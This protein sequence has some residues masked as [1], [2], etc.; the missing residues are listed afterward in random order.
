MPEGA[1]L[2]FE[3]QDTLY[4][5]YDKA[6]EELDEFMADDSVFEISSDDDDETDAD[7]NNGQDNGQDD[8]HGDE[9]E[10]IKNSAEEDSAMDFVV[11][12]DPDDLQTS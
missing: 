4:E 12:E 3:G 10:E 1:Q 5:D 2:I 7:E 9:A 8:G 11:E 6:L